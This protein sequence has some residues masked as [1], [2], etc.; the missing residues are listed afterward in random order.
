MGDPSSPT[1]DRTCAPCSGPPENS[2]L[3]HLFMHLW[4]VLYQFILMSMD[5]D[6]T[7]LC[8]DWGSTDLFLF[9]LISFVFWPKSYLI[10][11]NITQGI[12]GHT[13]LLWPTL[14]V[15]DSHSPDAATSQSSSCCCCRQCIRCCLC[16]AA[17]QRPYDP[18][19]WTIRAPA[20]IT[21][22][23]HHTRQSL[24]FRALLWSHA[25]PHCKPRLTSRPA[26]S[27]TFLS[28]FSWA[29]LL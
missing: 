24:L 27:R 13:A 1:R 4:A 7:G 15:P 10:K 26:Q 17:C 18:L 29:S 21:I 14:P 9:L 16:F 23:L 5:W 3:G 19:P 6:Y 12:Q 25:V 8:M 11:S 22:C 2:S 28:P 20:H